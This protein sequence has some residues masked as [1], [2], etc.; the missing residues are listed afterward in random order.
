MDYGGDYSNCRGIRDRD[1]NVNNTFGSCEDGGVSDDCGTSGGSEDSSC[2][3]CGDLGC[4]LCVGDI[5]CVIDG[6]EDDT[7]IGIDSSC[8]S[9]SGTGDGDGVQK[10]H[11]RRGSRGRKECHDDCSCITSNS[12]S[13][14]D[15]RRDGSGGC[16][17]RC[18]G[19]D[20]S[21]DCNPSG[22]GPGS[23]SSGGCGMDS[24][25]GGVA[26]GGR[27]GAPSQSEPGPSAGRALSPAAGSGSTGSIWAGSVARAAE[28]S[29]ACS[30]QV[31]PAL[32]AALESVSSRPASGWA[33]S[34]SPTPSLV[35]SMSVRPVS[36]IRIAT[37]LASVESGQDGPGA[38]GTLSRRTHEELPDTGQGRPGPADSTH[39]ARAK[40]A[41]ADLLAGMILCLLAISGAAFGYYLTVSV[42]M[43]LLLFNNTFFACFNSRTVKRWFTKKGGRLKRNK[44]AKEGEDPFK[45]SGRKILAKMDQNTKQ[46]L[47]KATRRSDADLSHSIGYLSNIKSSLIIRG[48]SGFREG[49]KENIIIEFVQNGADRIVVADVL[50]MIDINYDPLQIM[51]HTVV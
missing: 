48:D 9:Y 20:A 37:V 50:R 18:S 28:P 22:K 33:G 38:L 45:V 29:S 23:G 12:T 47:W 40:M 41:N 42:V 24:Y 1:I 7:G 21:G 46:A 17:G 14:G 31:E 49:I 25:A 6:T 10:A 32:H 16:S 5:G 3:R 26:A 13:R 19:F 27:N 35:V 4:M 30:T 11:G 36:A 39:L 15:D 51:M 2:K 44:T 34:R 8:D 43:V